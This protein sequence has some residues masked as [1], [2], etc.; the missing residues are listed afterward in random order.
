[1]PRGRSSRYSLPGLLLRNARASASGLIAMAAIV[2]VVSGLAASAPLALQA[3]TTDEIGYQ[4]GGLPAVQRDLIS[5][6]TFIP[7]PDPGADPFSSTDARLADLRTHTPAAL[8]ATLGTGQFVVESDP[9]EAVRAATGGNESITKVKLTVAP[10]VAEHLDVVEGKAPAPSASDR[11]DDEPVQIM[12]S[13]AVAEQMGW[14]V[15][16]TRQTTLEFGKNFPALLSGVFDP[17]DP[18]A[19]IWSYLPTAL[20]PSFSHT[21]FSGT[22]TRIVTGSAF[23]DPVSWR[24]LVEQYVIH[25]RT[26]IWYPFSADGLTVQK[27]Q[28][29]LPQLRHFLADSHAL[30]GQDVPPAHQNTFESPVT[31]HLASALERGATATAVLAMALAGPLGVAV[32][33]LW[34]LASLIVLRRRDA[35]ALLAARGAGG[36]HIRGAL[37][38]EA[39]IVSVP[40][41][42]VGAAIALNLFPGTAGA[43]SIFL[44]A[45]VAVIPALLTGITGSAP[46]LR[47]VR[48]D[49]TPSS[50]RPRLIAEIIVLALTALAVALLLQRGLVTSSAGVDPLLAATP[51][52]LAVSAAL[53]VM[54]VYPLPL[55]ALA[56]WFRSRR[57]FVAF[58]GAA[59]ATRDPAAGLVPVLALVV[60]VSVTAF[61]GVLLSTVNAGV[62]TTAHSAV[63]ADLRISG[64][65]LTE[66]D[67]GRIADIPGVAALATISLGAAPVTVDVTDQLFPAQLLVADTT[68]LA[69]VQRGVP[70][71][72]VMGQD[73]TSKIG[74][75]IPVVFSDPDAVAAS[76]E[77]VTFTKAPI[78]LV[79][80]PGT[81]RSLTTVDDWALVDAALADDFGGIN[82]LAPRLALLRLAPGIDPDAV[83]H[84]VRSILGDG[85][86]TITP[87]Q[88]AE[89]FQHSPVASGLVAS[90]I[91][92]VIAVGALCG[93]GVL[94]ALMIS[95]AA[96]ARLL[97]LLRT[98]GLT[99]AQSRGIAAWELAPAAIVAVVMG[100]ALGVVLTLVVRAGVDLRT[101]TGGIVQPPVTVD[102]LLLTAITGGFVLVVTGAAVIAAAAIRRINVAATLRT[103]EEG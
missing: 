9:Y 103:S 10:E 46:S 55:I 30:L 51:L 23:I 33:V 95:A 57:G 53:V 102:P 50:W 94:L 75:A 78:H 74:G 89:Q 64:V 84:Q 90:L 69:D 99:R 42:V 18:A 77:P 60:G 7:T 11:V 93:G 97:A 35:L 19:D 5:R 100:A 71:A 39:L 31:D 37:A 88:S 14:A 63:G 76:I 27:A 16:E 101:F 44:A 48:A 21:S 91:A 67:L 86:E 83:A 66:D 20:T 59:R 80:S 34:L 54:R 8:R 3:M 52:F 41:A 70:G 81:S 98:M 29:V 22:N 79:G 25:Q 26:T 24:T 45:A 13:S 92:M 28:A 43:T 2:L 82:V 87:A 40:A 4:I 65:D 47:A 61:S 68:A 36:W 58:L 56:G 49:L 38:L 96:R 73:M 6:S 72:A 1:M 32:A 62:Q 12:L 15:G 85:A 17:L